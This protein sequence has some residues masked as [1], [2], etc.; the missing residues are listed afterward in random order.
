[1]AKTNLPS[2]LK[3]AIDPTSITPS[4]PEDYL[5]RG[6]L[7]YSRGEYKLAEED[8]RKALSLNSDLIDAKYALALTLKARK[9]YAEALNHFQL[10]LHSTGQIEDKVKAAMLRRLVQGHINHIQNGDWNLEKEIWQARN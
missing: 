7:Y 5:K 6:W 4:T 9:D 1:M 8:L 2:D 3:N 10:V